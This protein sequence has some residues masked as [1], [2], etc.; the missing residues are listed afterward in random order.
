M[1]HFTK[2]K[3]TFTDGE[4]LKRALA[5][6]GFKVLDGRAVAG[7]R[8]RTA[9]AEFKVKASPNSSYEIGFSKQQ[10][11]YELVSDWSMNQVNQSRFVNELTR[12][13]GR[14]VVVAELERQGYVLEKEVVE[15]SELRIT[16]RR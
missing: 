4:A 13:Y 10:T 9:H 3:T 2:V 15:K 8:G 14:E 6:L 7:W 16:L 12:A 11:R 5:S 1:S